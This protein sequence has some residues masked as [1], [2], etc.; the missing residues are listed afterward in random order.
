MLFHAAVA[1][2]LLTLCLRYS[3]SESNE[4]VW[5]PVDSSEVLFGGEY[6]MVGDRQEMAASTNEPAPAE[7]E[8][9]EA[10]A[11]EAEALV[12]SGEP[13]QPAPVVSSERPSPA[14]VEK[15]P[16]PEKTGPTKAEI[17]AAERAKREQEARQ[18]I[19][20]KVQ[21]GQKSTG[22]NGSGKAGSADGNATVGAVSGSPG[23]NLKGRSL[24]DWHTPP[25][26]AR[27]YNCPCD[28]Q[29]SGQG[30][31]GVIFVRYRSSGSKPVD[32]SELH[33]CCEN[34]AVLGR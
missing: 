23:F 1:V 3:G 4:R 28:C 5:P 12:N 25:A 21:F 31:L 19:A 26:T 16:S 22:G 32:S 18:A 2:V 29:P 8:A 7:A 11:P 17:E 27:H 6:V 34:V 30:D 13:A 20:S 10:P 33:K 15:K 24:A 9:Q 14:K